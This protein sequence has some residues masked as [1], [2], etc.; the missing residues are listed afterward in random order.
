MQAIHALSLPLYKEFKR[1][2][3]AQT[4]VDN[5]FEVNH[6]PHQGPFLFCV[7]HQFDNVGDE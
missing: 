2:Y 1:W 6:I 5:I 7:F 4:L 3:L